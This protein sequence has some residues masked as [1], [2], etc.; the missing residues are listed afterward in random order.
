MFS[1]LKWRVLYQSWTESTGFCHFSES[2]VLKEKL[3]TFDSS[4]QLERHRRAASCG[5]YQL[6]ASCPQVVT[7]LL[8]SSSCSKSVKIRFVAAWY[9]QTFCQLLKQLASDLWIK[10]HDNQLAANLLATCSR[11]VIIKPE[12]AMLPCEQAVWGKYYLH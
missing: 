12:Q 11:L 1:Q 2:K 6:A 5:S 9:L 7:S 3:K 4:T 10:S 8:N